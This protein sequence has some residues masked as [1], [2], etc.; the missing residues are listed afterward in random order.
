MGDN[1]QSAE[2]PLTAVAA[3]VLAATLG[4]AVGRRPPWLIAGP[5]VVAVCGGV[6]I[7]VTP[8]LI[9]GSSCGRVRGRSQ[10]PLRLQA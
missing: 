7:T 3:A 6:F 2:E 1:P 5:L 4:V 10:Q 9:E 8:S